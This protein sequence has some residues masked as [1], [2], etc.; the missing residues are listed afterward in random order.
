MSLRAGAIERTR[1][2]QALARLR[3]LIGN[4]RPAGV[5]DATWDALDRAATSIEI[6]I[7]DRVDGL[8]LPAFVAIVHGRRLAMI[9]S[10][11]SRCVELD[12][13]TTARVV[14]AARSVV[15]SSRQ[16]VVRAETICR[17]RVDDSGGVAMREVAADA[18]DE[19]WT[20][21]LKSVLD[22]VG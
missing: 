11:R 8:P 21:L 16:V 1:R 14:A 6:R 17:L 20:R 22:A 2:H 19:G 10:A 12:E 5:D 18:M 15:T 4:E 7:D 13:I 9:T 3:G